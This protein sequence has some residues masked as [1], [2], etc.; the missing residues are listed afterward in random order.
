MQQKYIN[1]PIHSNKPF[2]SGP[3]PT[4]KRNILSGAPAFFHFPFSGCKNLM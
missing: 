4:G 3:G 1:F 2:L